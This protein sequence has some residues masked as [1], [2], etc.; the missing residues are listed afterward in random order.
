METKEPCRSGR[1]RTRR[2]RV[3]LAAAALLWAAQPAR[4]ANGF[5]TTAREWRD[6]PTGEGCEGASERVDRLESRIL[7]IKA[8]YWANHLRKGKSLAGLRVNPGST[9]SDPGLK[10]SF[11]KRMEYWYN[12][13]EVSELDAR[14]LQLFRTIEAKA[15]SLYRECGI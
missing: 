13:G 10:T 1:A 6:A 9:I 5:K 4:A 3:G 8:R 7:D 15:Y 2:I 12:R 11:Y 14:E